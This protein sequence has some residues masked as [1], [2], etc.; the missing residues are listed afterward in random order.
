MQ[1]YA[2]NG[3]KVIGMRQAHDL[4]FE[5]DHVTVSRFTN[6]LHDTS[7]RS[8]QKYGK[9]L[10]NLNLAPKL[11]DYVH[12]KRAEPTLKRRQTKK[13]DVKVKYTVQ[14]SIAEESF[15]KALFGTEQHSHFNTPNEQ[16]SHSK[17]PIE[18]I[19]DVIVLPQGWANIGS[20]ID[21]GL[22]KEIKGR[23]G[24]LYQLGKANPAVKLCS[25]K[26]LADILSS[27]LANSRKTKL[28]LTLTKV[29]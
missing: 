3:K 22:S 17:T 13:V 14:G 6:M 7:K 2:A 9:K 11:L 4:L 28:T 19:D 16:Y 26:V 27:S 20:K 1:H 24:D 29:I 8:C 10:L 25:E 12:S 15:Q 18:T 5:Q 21:Q 23:I